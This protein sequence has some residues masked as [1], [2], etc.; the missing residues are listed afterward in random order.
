M[1]DK[2]AQSVER[3]LRIVIVG[4]SVGF[5]VRPYRDRP[6]NGNYGDLL[7]GLLDEQGID[8]EV[9]NSAGWFLLLHEAFSQI[10]T[11]VLRHSPDVVITNFGMGECQP[12]VIP[13]DML[14][15]LFAWRTSSNALLQ[16]CR[17]VM[18]IP[19]SLFYRKISPYI[20]RAVPVPH[21]LSP[22]R[23]EFEMRR[24]AGVV[25]KERKALFL[26]LASNPP[27]PLLERT[28][29][30][31]AQRALRYNDILRRVADDMGDDVR[32]V[33][34]HDLVVREGLDKAMPDGIHF[35]HYGHRKVAEMLTEQIVS[36]MRARQSAA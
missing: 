36:W 6:E 27:G 34:V 16:A 21:R 23:F 12:K 13:T 5:Y 17:R 8:A 24:F 2:G 1:T 35:S 7:P 15:W 10:E 22:R 28:L 11:L 26:M 14:R 33:D 4:Q 32:F 19:V 3:P 9:V 29:P 20:I 31:T 30:G 18:V 25:R